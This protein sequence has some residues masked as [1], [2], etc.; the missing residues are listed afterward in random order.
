MIVN[1]LSS[2]ILCSY[3]N[4]KSSYVGGNKVIYIYIAY[5]YN[6]SDLSYTKGRHT[7]LN[8]KQDV[9]PWNGS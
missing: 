3:V 9:L 2:L 7:T 1:F 5:L 6:T 8:R 4:C